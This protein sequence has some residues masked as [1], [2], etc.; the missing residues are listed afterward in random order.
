MTKPEPTDPLYDDGKLIAW[1]DKTELTLLAH[2]ETLNIEGEA[3]DVAY[4]LYRDRTPVRCEDRLGDSVSVLHTTS[5]EDAIGWLNFCRCPIPV[6]LKVAWE[7]SRASGRTN[8]PTSSQLTAKSPIPVDG[9]G[10]ESVAPENA[11]HWPVL[12]AEGSTEIVEWV[13]STSLKSLC[14]GEELFAIHSDA[15]FTPTLYA[16]PNGRL[17]YA[18]CDGSRELYLLDSFDDAV[19]WLNRFRMPIP[20]AMKEFWRPPSDADQGATGDTELTPTTPDGPVSTPSCPVSIDPEKRKA[21][22]NGKPVEGQLTLEQVAVLKA[23]IGVYPTRLTKDEMGKIA[24][25]SDGLGTFK[26]LI[27]KAPWSTLLSSAGR[28]G[29]RYGWIPGTSK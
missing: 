24:G 17:F 12:K 29:A 15:V 1:V 3:V 10:N 9:T 2:P 5:F 8:E 7:A 28:A 16:C 26:R 25:V 23:L 18:Y 11:E 14:S 27:E 13:N 4:Y 6:A 20:P 22:L 21:F 19:K